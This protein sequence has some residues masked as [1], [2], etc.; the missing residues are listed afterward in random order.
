VTA[1]I[2]QH[3]SEVR[4]AVE[5]LGPVSHAEVVLAFLRAE[6]DST[7]FCD[8]LA[9]AIQHLQSSRETLIDHAD[10]GR[11]DHNRARE[12]LIAA[13]RD[14]LFNR[15]PADVVWSRGNVSLGEVEQFQYPNYRRFFELSGGRRTV[16]T[17]ARRVLSEPQLLG[18]ELQE[19]LSCIP[20]VI[21]SASTAGKLPPLI[22]VRDPSQAR[23]VLVK[24]SL[25]ATAYVVA[26]HPA[27]VDV[28]L[29]ASARM[30]EWW[31][32]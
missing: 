29:G 19:M 31:L 11:E 21:R 6:V 14:P 7:R 8:R 1:A 4:A 9:R 26:R 20:G 25:R 12:W 32:F 2:Q 18:R 3:E 13:T 15:F 16:R 28:Y 17:G 5:Y 22:A 23:F 30:H 24:G 10:L 27:R